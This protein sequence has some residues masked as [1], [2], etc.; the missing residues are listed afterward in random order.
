MIRG[1]LI[2]GLTF[3]RWWQE[4]RRLAVGQLRRA[5]KKITIA[6][7]FSFLAVFC[8]DTLAAVTEMLGDTF[9]GNPAE[10]TLTPKM[11]ITAGTMYANTI[12]DFKGTHLGNDGSA[13]SRANDYLPYVLLGYRYNDKLVFGFNVTPRGY[14]HL[15]YDPNSLVSSSSIE[16]NILI[17][18]ISPRVGYQLTKTLAVGAGLDIFHSR[19]VDLSNDVI[20]QGILV[21]SS[22]GTRVGADIGL[23]YKLNPKNFLSLAFFSPAIFQTTGISYINTNVTHS[24]SQL[25]QDAAVTYLGLTHIL[26]AKWTLFEKIYWS[27]W[28]IKKRF[29]FKNTII[30]S[31]IVP[32]DWKDTWSFQ[33][34]SRY[35]VNS[36]LGVLGVVNYDTNPVGSSAK[37]YVAY[38][39]GSAAAFA[40]G[41][42]WTLQK[43]LTALLAYGYVWFVP[44]VPIRTTIDQGS[45]SLSSNSITLQLTYSV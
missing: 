28:S 18:E 33:L 27:G 42:D 2:D 39:V 14:G 9:F 7:I 6:F 15:K 29:Y 21:N 32:A 36:C 30:G 26:N 40:L 22:N 20:G 45:I 1:R 41:V 13:K 16:T 43:D 10:L 35:A 19:K 38:P 4:A 12:L 11:K 34:G 31:Y 25:Y 17:Y 23:F 37:N 8:L 44:K 24:Y 5:M 3:T